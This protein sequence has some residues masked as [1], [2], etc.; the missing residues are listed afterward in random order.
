MNKLDKL[1]WYV[2]FGCWFVMLGIVVG[3]V[4]RPWLGVGFGVSSF[5]VFA[6][7]ANHF[8]WIK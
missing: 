3:V 1:L 8:K 7:A 5:V 6:Y 4:L 2:I